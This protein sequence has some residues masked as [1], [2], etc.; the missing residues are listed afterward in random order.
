MFRKMVLR[1][2]FP[3]IRG[4]E[5]I[6]S[7]SFSTMKRKSPA[8]IFD[9]Q[10]KQRQRDRAASREDCE[11]FTYLKDEFGNRLAD[12]VFDVKRTF[13]IMIDMG[14]GQGHISRNL[15]E[16]SI[17]C[18]KISLMYYFIFRTLFKL[19]SSVILHLIIWYVSMIRAFF[20]NFN[21]ILRKKPFCQKE[22]WK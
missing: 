19:F 5:C 18:V 3:L 12:R 13:P 1:N 15:S 4:H 11:T 21:Q 16:V 20:S 8:D 10:A 2:Y 7:R 14:C 6:F 9:R 17:S 22:K